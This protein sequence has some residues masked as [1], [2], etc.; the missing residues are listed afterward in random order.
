MASLPVKMQP[1]S[2][3]ILTLVVIIVFVGEGQ[4]WSLEGAFGKFTVVFSTSPNYLLVH[5]SRQIP[6]FESVLCIVVEG[7]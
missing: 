1:L 5:F 4:T 3:N 7:Y 2:R 6:N